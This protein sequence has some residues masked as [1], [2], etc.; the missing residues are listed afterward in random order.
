MPRM[1][2]TNKQLSAL[3]V[4]HRNKLDMRQIDF[5]RKLGL[6]TATSVCRWE[7]DESPIPWIHYRQISKIL[8]IPWNRLLSAATHDN[9]E[10]VALFFE[11]E[12][13]MR[14]TPTPT[15]R[16]SSLSPRPDLMHRLDALT[17]KYKSADLQ[18]LIDSALEL[19]LDA[20]EQS[21]LDGNW[22]PIKQPF[23]SLD[24][25]AGGAA[26]PPRSSKATHGTETRKSA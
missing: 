14:V 11:S 5:A 9:P 15:V 12:K 8:D 4:E 2:P 10:H 26:G 7:K 21:G 17:A 20:A 23:H 19:Y 3:I 22:H 24:P 1:S 6:N 18:S 13:R 25:K 16:Q